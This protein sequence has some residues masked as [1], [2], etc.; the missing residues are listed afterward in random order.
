MHDTVD[1]ASGTGK[2]EVDH[3]DSTADETS[4]HGKSHSDGDR[5]TKSS[6]SAQAELS[7]ESVEDLSRP[8]RCFPQQR[9]NLCRYFFL[10]G[11]H[12]LFSGL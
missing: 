5:V 12:A 10:N 4:R 1:D 3:I 9:F 11:L 7:M 8:D 6:S 2:E